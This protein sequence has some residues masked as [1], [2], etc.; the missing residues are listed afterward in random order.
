MFQ[1]YRL[2]GFIRERKLSMYDFTFSNNERKIKA[3]VVFF[4]KS[5]GPLYDSVE[6]VSHGILMLTNKRLLFL[7]MGTGPIK[8]NC[9]GLKDISGAI[10]SAIVPGGINCRI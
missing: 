10:V 7:Y 1:W 2:L 4:G 6:N 9:G 3:D 8:E 5:N